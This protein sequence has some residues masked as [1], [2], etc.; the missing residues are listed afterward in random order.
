MRL[1]DQFD[2]LLATNFDR[3]ILFQIN[4]LIFRNIPNV[5]TQKVQ[6][7]GEIMLAMIEVNYSLKAIFAAN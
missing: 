4:L 1:Y 5:G 2:C 7:T 6:K 3:S